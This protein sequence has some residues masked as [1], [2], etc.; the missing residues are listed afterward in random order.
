VRPELH[1][2]AGIVV[3]D[4]VLFGV[5]V[6]PHDRQ[7]LQ[8]KPRLLECLDGR[9]RLGMGRVDTDHCVVLSHGFPPHVMMPGHVLFR[10]LRWQDR[11]PILHLDARGAVPLR[12]S[13][14][15]FVALAKSIPIEH[16][17]DASHM[18]LT[19]AEHCPG[20]VR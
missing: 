4:D 15:L 13:V 5:S 3:A 7:F 8:V 2:V 18:A 10:R 20:T 17:R 14:L 1:T 19:P 16:E 12:H 6:L 9:F 11:T